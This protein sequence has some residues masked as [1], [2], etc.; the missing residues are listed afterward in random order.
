[1]KL[2]LV[3]HGESI[4]NYE[5]RLQGHAD[6]DLTDLGQ[7]QAVLTSERLRDEGVTAVYTSPLLRAEATANTIAGMLGCQPRPLPGV[8]EY[9]F[10]DMAGSTYAEVRERF[11]NVGL[12]D[13]VYAGEEGR[14]AFFTRVTDSVWKVIDSH[15]GEAVAVVSHGGPIALFCQSVLGLPYKRP[16]PFVLDNC[17]LN[18]IEASDD[19]SLERVRRCV[20]VHLNDRCHLVQ[21][22]YEEEA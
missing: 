14:D 6:Y 12:A 16:M 11:Q 17:S 1:M 9:D 8:S 19:T 10:G 18:I 5:N 21:S 15:P 22:T 4:G 2:Y 3:R 20:L 13:R 7:Q